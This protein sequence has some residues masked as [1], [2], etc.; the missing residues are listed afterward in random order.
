M[1]DVIANVDPIVVI[2]TKREC[3]ENA[4]YKIE[5]VGSERNGNSNVFKVLGKNARRK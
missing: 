5:K 2:H 3:V 4:D 1:Q